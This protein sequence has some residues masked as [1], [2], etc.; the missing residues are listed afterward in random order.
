[1]I[2]ETPGFVAH[3]HRVPGNDSWELWLSAPSNGGSYIIHT[4]DSGEW[5][6]TSVDHGAP[7]GNTGGKPVLTIPGQFVGAIARAFVEEWGAGRPDPSSEA[8]VLRES[9][10]VER[11][12]VDAVLGRVLGEAVR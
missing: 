1:M 7:L 11:K 9:L 12:R 5:E 4:D 6:Y 10:E 2:R 3:L 8:R